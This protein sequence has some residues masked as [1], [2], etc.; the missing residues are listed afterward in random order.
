M[1]W[2]GLKKRLPDADKKPLPSREVLI[3]ATEKANT[4]TPFRKTKDYAFLIQRYTACRRGAAN[5]LRHCDIDLED[6][7]ITFVAWEKMV[8]YQ[9]TRGGKRRE[10]QIRRLKSDK[11]ERTVP[12][13][14]PLYD[15]IKDMPLIKGSN[16]PI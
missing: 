10:K 9:K 13:S 2:N 5:G 12:M 3:R 16:D 15:S 1:E 11:D 6:K 4:I 8:T 7:T 14:K